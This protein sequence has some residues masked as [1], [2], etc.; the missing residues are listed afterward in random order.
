MRVLRNVLPR[1]HRLKLSTSAYNYTSVEYA[2]EWQKTIAAKK[3][4]QKYRMKNIVEYV[5]LG[6]LDDHKNLV[7]V[8]TPEKVQEH[9][10]T[11]VAGDAEHNAEVRARAARVVK[12]K[13][14]A[15]KLT[16]WYPT[17][18]KRPTF[19][20]IYLDTY[21]RENVHLVDTS[22][23][24]VESTTAQG[25]VANGQE[26]PIDILILNTGHRSPGVGSGNPAA[27]TGIETVGRDG[28][29]MTHE[30]LKGARAGPSPDGMMRYI[31]ELE[32]CGLMFVP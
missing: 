2:V 6:A 27:R 11:I 31:H 7:G 29:S 25:I 8:I 14:T 26:Y 16:S 10:G 30:M 3:G 20:D 15:E 21:N 24:G 28:R 1:F 22:G 17:W 23:K 13:G 4:W 19:S 18:C 12:D 5:A 9:I 32:A